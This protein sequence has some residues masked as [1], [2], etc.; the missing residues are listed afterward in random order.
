MTLTF[1]DKDGAEKL[2][3]ADKDAKESLQIDMANKKVTLISSGDLEIKADQGAVK[4]SAK[5]LSIETSD[6]SEVKASGTL[7]LNGSTV[8]VK[9]SPN[10]NLN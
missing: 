4:I 7:D 3:L 8:N 1:D 10:V 2:E 9:G 6:K 5:T